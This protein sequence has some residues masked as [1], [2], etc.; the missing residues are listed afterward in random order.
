ME[1]KTKR[2]KKIKNKKW[3]YSEVLVSSLGTH[4][5]GPDE[6]RRL[7]WKG[8]GEKEGLSLE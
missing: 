7:Q 2:W 8:L 3:I 1:P 6:K 4:G 5:V